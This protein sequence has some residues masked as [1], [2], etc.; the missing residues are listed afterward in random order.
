MNNHSHDI[1]ELPAHTC[2]S[3][4]RAATIGRLAVW[5]D[6]HPDI[7]PLNYVTDH[8]TIVFRSDAGTKVSGALAGT[9]VALEIDGYDAQTGKAWSVVV[10]G[11]A[12]SIKVGHELMATLELPLF[13]WQAGIKGHFLRITPD[14]VTGRRFTVT[15]PETWASPMT[16]ALRTP[17]GPV[18]T[19]APR[20]EKR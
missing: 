19:V 7:F 14:S 12:E 1:E 10:K 15:D 16:T 20:E 2:W 8:G 11:Q 13:P 9:P 17:T 4:L 3:L 6:D 5:V 18:N